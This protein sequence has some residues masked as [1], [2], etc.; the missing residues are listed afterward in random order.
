MRRSREARGRVGGLG[1]RERELA[2][3]GG[4]SRRVWEEREGLEER[5]MCLIS[6]LLS[7]SLSVSVR[8][9]AEPRGGSEEN[10]PRRRSAENRERK[11]DREK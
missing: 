5:V 1:E 9:Q 8:L 6:P 10:A 3:S 2:F 11:R 7:L 4:E